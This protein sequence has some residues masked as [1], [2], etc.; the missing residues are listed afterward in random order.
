MTACAFLFFFPV[1]FLSLPVLFLSRV[2]VVLLFPLVPSCPAAGHPSLSS[3]LWRQQ[4]SGVGERHQGVRLWRG[5]MAGEM[6]EKGFGGRKSGVGVG[7]EGCRIV[8]G[9]SVG[10]E[11]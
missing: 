2:S 11:E 8:E 3:Q 6:V 4:V 5:R 9:K 7:V 1:F 10:V